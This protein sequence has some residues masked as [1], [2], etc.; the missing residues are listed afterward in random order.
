MHGRGGKLGRSRRFCGT[1][2]HACTQSRRLITRRSQKSCPATRKAP[3]TGAFP[4]INLL[5]LTFSFGGGFECR[6]RQ[7]YLADDDKKR[8]PLSSTMASTLVIHR[9]ADPMFS[10]PH[11][12]GSRGEIPACNFCHSREPSTAPGE[13]TGTSPREHSSRTPPRSRWARIRVGRQPVRHRARQAQR[14]DRAAQRSSP[15]FLP[16]QSTV[17]P[18]SP[19][20]AR[21]R[22][23]APPLAH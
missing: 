19:R 10:L 12:K 7:C 22:G 3:E 14:H 11:G 1:R 23:R 15:T 2:R 4:S 6:P 13:P 17:S 5:L 18:R 20:C 9:T 8:E 16:P 21:S